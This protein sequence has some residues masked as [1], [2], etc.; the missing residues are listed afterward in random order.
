MGSGGRGSTQSGKDHAPSTL[1][2]ETYRWLHDSLEK[3]LSDERGLL[4]TT[5]T[6][7]I[8]VQAASASL[9]AYLLTTRFPLNEL[10]GIAGFVAG[11]GWGASL[12][13][14]AIT[15]RGRKSIGVWVLMLKGLET[16][17][18][19]APLERLKVRTTDGSEFTIEGDLAKP[20]LTHSAVLSII[21]GRDGYSPKDGR[22]YSTPHG[23]E[24]IANS[25]VA[26]WMVIFFGTFGLWLWLVVVPSAIQLVHSV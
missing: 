24:R 10:V 7:L 26:I 5:F 20:N 19:I 15:V 18:P 8:G 22:V 9:L 6:L 13:N 21:E 1:D 23:L 4:L 25:L 16:R 11:P 3:S 12:V 17:S 14:W 2:P